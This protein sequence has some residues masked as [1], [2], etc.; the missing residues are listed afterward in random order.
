MRFKFLL[1]LLLPL[2]LILC[3]SSPIF[4]WN[5][6]GHRV[7]AQIAYDQLTPQ[8]KQKI[9]ALTA[10]MFHSQYPADRFLCAATWPDQ[11]KMQ[12]TQYNA[13]H[14]INLPYIKNNIQPPALNS[15]NIVWAITYAEKIVADTKE[16]NAQRAKI[17]SFLIHFVGDIEQ[18]LHCTTL[19]DTQ[20]PHGD[21]GGNNY[22]I[23][24]PIANNLHQ[25][26]DR[27]IGL[28]Y[29]A[30]NNYQ[31]HYLQV[32]K[33]ATKWMNEY[34]TSFFAKQLAE[35]SPMQWARE[36]RQIAVTFAYQL[37]LNATPSND[38]I[39]QGQTIVRE[40]SVLAGDRLAD[41]LNHIF[42]SEH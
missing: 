3:F 39:Q 22:L 4:A 9:D 24:S 16:N 17:L 13:W 33:I 1:P 34:P 41:I 15:Q 8:T 27:G 36:S 35:K 11:L 12:T 38:Y 26:W 2:L 40:Q 23:H 25:L 42:L 21:R 30:P 31:F 10:V 37:P 18:P 29:S 5:N 28:F 14:Y 19:Y 6:V 7:I 32:E 20:F